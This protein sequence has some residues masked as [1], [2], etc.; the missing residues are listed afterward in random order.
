MCEFKSGAHCMVC[1]W[2]GDGHQIRGPTRNE[3]DREDGLS[4]LE[5]RQTHCATSHRLRP[6]HTQHERQVRTHACGTGNTHTHTPHTCP[7]TRPRSEALGG[8]RQTTTPRPPCSAHS[9]NHHVFHPHRVSTPPSRLIP[10]L[11]LSQPDVPRASR[12]INSRAHGVSQAEKDGEE[13]ESCGDKCQ[14]EIGEAHMVFVRGHVGARMYAC[15]RGRVCY[16]HTRGWCRV[17]QPT[18]NTSAQ[19]M[20]M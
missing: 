18:N 11:P 17:K 2:V 20:I 15:R 6:H 1:G 3:W 12:S 10:P 7:D 16:A 14:Q 13:R 9:H 5:G 4:S 8:V 19:T